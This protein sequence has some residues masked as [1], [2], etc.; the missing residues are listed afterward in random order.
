MIAFLTL[1]LGLATGVHPVE[2]AVPPEVARVELRLD[3]EAVATL[4]GPPWRAEVDLGAELLPRRLEARAFAADGGSLGVAEQWINMPASSE[5]G[6]LLLERDEKG[7][8][9]AARVVWQSVQ[10]TR[11]GRIAVHLDGEELPV[12]DDRVTIPPYDPEQAHVL[13]A[14]LEFPD[15]ETV[16]DHVLFGGTYG[17]ETDTELTAVALEVERR[18]GLRNLRQA[19]GLLLAGG[20]PARV[21]ALDRGGFDLLVVAGRSAVRELARM[22]SGIGSYEIRARQALLDPSSD[23]SRRIP[24]AHAGMDRGDRL[25]FMR[26]M[27][28]KVSSGTRPYD[29]FDLTSPLTDRDGG[30]PWLL[31]YREPYLDMPGEPQRLADA[32]AN[33]ASHAAGTGRARAILLLVGPDSEDESAFSPASVRRYLATLGV[34]LRIWY[35]DAELDVLNG[36]DKEEAEREEEARLL[37]A[38][39]AGVEPSTHEERLARVEARWEVPVLVLTRPHELIE[40]AEDLG[41]ELASQRVVWIEG[42]WLPREV[43]VVAGRGVSLPD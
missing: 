1:F 22:R 40:A 38:A 43:E 26:P 30:I 35:L 20:R 18:R 5:A 19:E 17:E 39:E 36:F 33:A 10:Y 12:A 28:R 9:A 32:V 15:G 7:R 25:S 16:R 14:E 21:A 3:G 8:V 27:A 24:D 34:P 4:D 2:L 37:A 41:R 31:T 29:I 6:G 11:P 42:R 13:S 23:P